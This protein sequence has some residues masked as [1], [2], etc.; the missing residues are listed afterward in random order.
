MK[1]EQDDET[2]DRDTMGGPITDQPAGA[3]EGASPDQQAQQARCCCGD[4][5]GGSAPTPRTDCVDRMAQS[6]VTSHMLGGSTADTINEI[7]ALYSEHARRLEVSLVNAYAHGERMAAGW[8]VLKDALEVLE[9]HANDER[10]F[11]GK[12]D[13]HGFAGR[14]ADI[15]HRA[16]AALSPNDPGQ[17]RP[18]ER[19]GETTE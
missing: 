1:E 18:G 9:T 7:V 10:D 3:S 15:Y 8:L 4:G 17:P 13:K 14:A 12:E 6:I 19:K 2:S 16:V 11:W 5:L